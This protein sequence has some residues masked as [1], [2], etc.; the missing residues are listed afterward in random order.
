MSITI[1][2][3]YPEDCIGKTLAEIEKTY[4]QAQTITEQVRRRMYPYELYKAFPDARLVEVEMQR[5]TQQNRALHKGARILAETL[6]DAGL[7]AKKTLKPEASI[8]WTMEMIL[9]LM[10]KPIMS[11][12]YPDTTST[13]ELTTKQVSYI[14]EVMNRHLSERFGIAVPFPGDENNA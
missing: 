6:N 3:L 14:W 13:T 10:Y 4:G 5:T 2:K 7:D 1:N 12:M 11:A 9:D 8:P